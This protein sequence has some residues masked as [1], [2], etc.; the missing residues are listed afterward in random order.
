MDFT[1]DT[2]ELKSAVTAASRAQT[3]AHALP[4]LDGLHIAYDGTEVAITGTRLDL[5]T[6]AAIPAHSGDA[7]GGAV[8]VNAKA[9]QSALKGVKVGHVRVRNTIDHE[10]HIS[11]NGGTVIL[12][13]LPLEDWPALSMS[14]E[15]HTA[16]FSSHALKAAL[17]QVLACAST[18]MT[19]PIL[20]GALFAAE[21]DGTRLVA[22]DSYRLAVL[23]LP[24]VSLGI[25]E[26]LPLIIPAVALKEVHRA[27][28]KLDT[29]MYLEHFPD[30]F[31]RFTVSGA[32]VTTRLIE[33]EFPQYRQLIPATF[34]GTLDA[35]RETLLDMVTTLSNGIPKGKKA[36]ATPVRIS[37]GA[38]RAQ[39]ITVTIPDQGIRSAV[40][41]GTYC[42]EDMEIAFNPGF[43][44]DGLKSITGDT[45][46]LQVQ[47]PLKPAV[48]RGNNPDH[49]C[50]LMPVR[51]A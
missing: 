39:E 22:T 17:D 29:T 47:S 43:L 5:T 51:L 1:V 42:G 20:T 38:G 8:V 32:V 46:T 21:G 49:Q 19:R 4:I 11:H 16:D 25:A 23:D 14:G 2:K 15:R 48:L 41:H 10:M 50:L 3:R 7:K 12:N 37:L 34:S 44:A 35:P 26:G 28:G 27:I 9:L 30:G 31:V 45:V 18:D 6:T 40:C 33:G 24:N 13:T 36:E